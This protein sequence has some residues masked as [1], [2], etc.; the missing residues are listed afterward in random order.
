MNLGLGSL[1]EF[2]YTV[3]AL[4]LS[5]VEGLYPV[6]PVDSTWGSGEE[7]DSIHEG[8]AQGWHSRPGTTKVCLAVLF[9]CLIFKTPLFLIDFF[10]LLIL[11]FL[12]VVKLRNRS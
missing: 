6:T 8:S 1:I 7:R 10:G 4:L 2:N 5:K 11:V 3:H 9:K 12:R